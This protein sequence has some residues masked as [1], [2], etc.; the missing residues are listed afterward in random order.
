MYCG[1]LLR[2]DHTDV[3]KKHSTLDTGSQ[4]K[5][6]V[7]S[8]VLLFLWAFSPSLFIISASSHFLSSVKFPQM[9]SSSIGYQR[10][11]DGL[12]CGSV[13]S[14]FIAHHT[15]RHHK[16]NKSKAIKQNC[17]EIFVSYALLIFMWL[18]VPIPDLQW[19]LN[20][21]CANSINQNITCG[22]KIFFMIV[23]GC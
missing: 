8:G 17:E 18:I 4:L 23:D 7:V 5:A 16:R 14:V 2:R 11:P 15:H 6:K 1:C 9:S 20:L 12:C 21:V 13:R 19:Q 22:M 3:F 10:L